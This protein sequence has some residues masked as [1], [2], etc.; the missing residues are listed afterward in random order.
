MRSSEAF[1]TDIARRA[2]WALDHNGGRPN[3]A[4][5]TGEQLI[6]A[7]VLYRYDFLAENG[8]TADEVKGRIGGDIGGLALVDDWLAKARAGV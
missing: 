3:G 6:V 5:S 8:W 1:S 4:W 7:L 2:R